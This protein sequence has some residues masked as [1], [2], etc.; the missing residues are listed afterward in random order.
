MAVSLKDEAKYRVAL[1]GCGRA[2]LPRARAFDMHPLCQVVALADTDV[3]N[4]ALASGF[5]DAPGYPSY[6]ELFANEQ[7]DIAAAVLPVQPNA[8][9]VVAAAEAGAKAIFCEK[10]LTASLVDADRMV[11]ACSARGV[12]FATGVVIS[13]HAEYQR[14]YA[15]AAAGEIGAVRRINLYEGNGQGG[16]HGLNLVR[17]FAGR[18]QV[19]YVIGRVEGDPQS[20]Y[21]RPH[22]EGMAVVG[23]VGGYIRFANGIECF[24]SWE[25]VGWRGIE[26]VGTEGMICN[27]NNTAVGLRLFKTGA[28]RGMGLHEVAGVFAAYE[29]EERGYD[30]DGWRDP[31]PTMKGIVQELVDALEGERELGATTGDDMRHA[32]EIAIALRESHRRR[33]AAVELPLAD[34]SLTMYPEKARWEYK[35]EVYGREWYM[36]QMAQVKRS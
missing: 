13:S 2:G 23:A 34:R 4:L 22:E 20:D 10:P 14:A 26:V 7:I 3:E 30:A 24:S 29:E 8:G 32:L 9:A 12:H 15:L 27:W 5:F 17:R 25:E 31:G 1:I 16:C 33:H 21:E 35:K 36:E 11:A 28:Q 18:A 6:D 19:E